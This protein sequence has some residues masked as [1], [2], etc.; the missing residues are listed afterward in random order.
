VGRFLALAKRRWW[1]IVLCAALGAG[2]GYLVARPGGEGY[3]ARALVAA[4]VPTVPP[5]QVSTVLQAIFATDAVLAPT[6]AEVGVDVTPRYLAASGALSAEPGSSDLAVTIVGRSSDGVLAADLAN[7]AADQLASVAEANG[8]GTYAVFPWEG[9]ATA[10]TGQVV[11]PIVAGALAGAGL[12][13]LGLLLWVS[14]RRGPAGREELAYADVTYRLSVL[15]GEYGSDQP[16]IDPPEGLTSLIRTVAAGAPERRRVEAI[17]GDGRPG[18][19]AC[20]EVA[21]WLKAIPADEGDDERRSLDEGSREGGRPD[22]V[23]LVASEDVPLSRL[24]EARARLEP[25]DGEAIVVLALLT[26]GHS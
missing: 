8:F 11:V 2:V 14:V 20:A 15:P 6:S 26:I 5:D 22:V 7:T 13:V 4:T 12:A 17:D 24:L 23:A 25:S 19:W 1:V 18:S 9:D 21:E 3:T 10:T 16:L